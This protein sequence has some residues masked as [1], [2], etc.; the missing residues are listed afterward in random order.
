MSSSKSLCLMAFAMVALLGATPCSADLFAVLSSSREVLRIDSA[1]G[2]VTRKYPFPEWLAV[3]P[4][5]T[6]GLAFDGRVL[7][8]NARPDGGTEY[9]WQLDVVD[10]FWYPEEFLDTFSDVSEELVPLTGLG[11]LP[12]DPGTG[13]LI[14][15]SRNFGDDPPSHIFQYEII[16]GAPG[17]FPISFPPGQL[18]AGMAA[19][20]AD[21]DPATGDLW[22]GVAD[23]G[24]GNPT[25]RLLRTDLAGTVLETLTPDLGPATIIRGVGF[26]A[27]AMFI[28]V[29]NLPD[30]TNEI[31]EIDRSTGEVLRSFV[32]PGDG[33]IG[34]LT[35]GAVI[36]EP[37][38]LVLATLAFC[39]LV[40][41]CRR[42]PFRLSR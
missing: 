8:L 3:P 33:T 36:P 26:D 38:G 6:V 42:K 31:Y 22:I 25:P 15:V 16:G 27:D 34:A 30:V 35:G 28:G 24:E 41:S 40:V 29:R 11:Y 2:D 13:I 4:S 32:L 17:V 7:Y 18:P 19:D 5:S 23:L 12:G 39:G 21:I 20:G 37:G 1:T 9:L 14:G 10:N